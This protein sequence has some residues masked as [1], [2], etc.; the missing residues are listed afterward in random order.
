[1]GAATERF[2]TMK[3]LAI[4]M[5]DWLKDD[6]YL[7]PL[8]QVAKKFAALDE[9][10]GKLL[11]CRHRMGQ[12]RRII[13]PGDMK[14]KA[15]FFACQVNDIAIGEGRFQNPPSIDKRAVRAAEI[16]DTIFVTDANDFGMLLGNLAGIN[17]V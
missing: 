17:R 8:E 6:A 3:F 16:A 4:Q 11:D 9:A 13:G 1:M 5:H 12:L 10:V 7:A 14:R 15:E 2:V